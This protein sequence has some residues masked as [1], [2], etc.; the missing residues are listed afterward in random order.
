M[1]LGFMNTRFCKNALE[2]TL[3][4]LLEKPNAFYAPSMAQ[5]PGL[6]FCQAYGFSAKL[7]RV[8]LLNHFEH[9]LPFHEALCI[10]VIRLF[11]DI[12]RNLLLFV[13]YY[14]FIG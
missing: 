7:Q 10:L 8:S 12:G 5:K 6:A 13:E 4:L 11:Y 14:I 3:A 1:Q 9:A 2:E